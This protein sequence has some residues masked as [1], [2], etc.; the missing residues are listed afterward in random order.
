MTRYFLT[1]IVLGESYPQGVAHVFTHLVGKA[2]PFCSVLSFQGC[3]YNKHPWK[4]EL[5]SWS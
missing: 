3:L 5:V 4:A 2:L 1:I